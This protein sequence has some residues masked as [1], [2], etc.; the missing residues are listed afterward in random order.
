[1]SNV[2]KLRKH[3]DSA[4]SGKYSNYSSNVENAMANAF[5][6]FGDTEYWKEFE[7]I[8]TLRL[9]DNFTN[10]RIN[11]ANYDI[12]FDT[13]SEYEKASLSDIA[14][15]IQ[16]IREEKRSDPLEQ[17]K[18]QRTAGINPDLNGNIGAGEVAEFDNAAN[19]FD[20]PSSLD[21]R[22]AFVSNSSNW[23]SMVQEGLSAAFSVVQS[24][25]GITGQAMQNTSVGISNMESFDKL[26]LDEIAGS[27]PTPEFDEN[28]HLKT[29]FEEF[30]DLALK[31]ANALASSY[32]LDSASL[33]APLRKGYARAF[34]LWSIDAKTNKLPIATKS[35]IEQLYKDYAE[36]KLASSKVFSNPAWRDNDGAMVK[37]YFDTYAEIEKEVWD[38]QQFFLKSQ[39]EIGG[40][41]NNVDIATYDALSRQDPNGRFIDDRA[42]L[43]R[44]N[45]TTAFDQNS[46]IRDTNE[47]IRKGNEL[48]RT[49]IDNASKIEETISKINKKFDA[50]D[51]YLKNS[52]SLLAPVLRSV[53]PMIEQRIITELREQMSTTFIDQ[54]SGGINQASKLLGAID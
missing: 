8:P 41:K 30:E 23:F 24:V 35:K 22:S 5:A 19:Q 11:N 7:S 6:E 54:L 42:K 34:K 9:P 37:A 40:I 43:M 53:L 14:Q 49:S 3:L 25:Q 17:V 29:S 10:R 33:P 31:K 16:T 39:Y 32:K 18:R 26:I 15:I 1:M 2:E 45:L 48:K 12:F 28:G 46:T 20:L 51:D 38:L 36:N 27:M 4:S 13:M 47:T 50:L 52:N 21:A 44:D